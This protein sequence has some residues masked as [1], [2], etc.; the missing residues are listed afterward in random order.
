MPQPIEAAGQERPAT[1]PQKVI[2]TYQFVFW[3]VTIGAVLFECW[4][5]V[6]MPTPPNNRE[7][8]SKFL[9]FVMIILLGL[10]IYGP[11]LHR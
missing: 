10:G 11:A 9:L 4:A 7:R 2:M 8:V 1:Q 6:N 3:L 5:R